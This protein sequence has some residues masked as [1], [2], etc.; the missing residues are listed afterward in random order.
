MAKLYKNSNL[1]QILSEI[2]DYRNQAQI[3]YT[4]PQ[5]LVVVF[6]GVLVGMKN[7]LHIEQFA[8]QHKDW[9]K[10]NLGLQSI[11]SH[12]TIDR[13]MQM[14]SHSELEAA[15]TIWL[16]EVL[17]DK[18]V[19]KRIMIDGK[20]IIRHCKKRT[21]IVRALVHGIFQVKAG[22][23]I[24]PSE[25]EII[26]IPKLLKK[27]AIKGYLVSIDAIGTQFKIVDLLVS[28]GAIALL[29]V[30]KNQKALYED[31]FLYAE[32][33]I[34]DGKGEVFEQENKG[35]GREERRKVY[36]FNDVDWLHKRH[37]KWRHIRSFCLLESM[38]KE[39][40][41]KAVTTRS[42][43]IATAILS[44][45]TFAVEIR[46]H[47]GIENNL[48]WTLNQ[49]FSENRM[50]SRCERYIFNFSLFLT[51]AL[52]LINSLKPKKLSFNSYKNQLNWNTDLIAECLF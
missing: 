48:H 34:K 18:H 11:P 4:Q 43:C 29:W 39:K 52:T 20:K 28:K 12:D 38:R 33:E 5:V 40:N 14:V 44:A 24:Q 16:D 9:F 3:V 49:S 19:L 15:L 45:E 26:A 7:S 42:I 23:K 27:M 51:T 1:M 10:A 2:H 6:I 31:L 50:Q 30:K 21:N 47:W 13:I 37:P 32:T 46:K 17:K 35:H 22:I 8:N 25:N 36:S 41:K